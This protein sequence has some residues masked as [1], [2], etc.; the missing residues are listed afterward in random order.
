MQEIRPPRD[1]VD[2]KNPTLSA[3]GELFQEVIDPLE[4]STRGVGMKETNQKRLLMSKAKRKESACSTPIPRW[5][6]TFS[7]LGVW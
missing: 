2:M 6:A 4:M 3:K 7:P 5:L 1:I